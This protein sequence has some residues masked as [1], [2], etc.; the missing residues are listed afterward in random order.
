MAKQYTQKS[1]F[2]SKYTIEPTF[3]ADHQYLAELI[4]E[5]IAAKEGVKL[6]YNFWNTD[7]WRMVFVKQCKHA[8]DLLKEYDVFLIIAALKDF[9]CRKVYSLGARYILD[10]ILKDL[11]KLQMFNLAKEYINNKKDTVNEEGENETMRP[12]FVRK[13]P[14]GEL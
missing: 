8:S 5:R 11:V 7:R 6:S 14:L 1:R 9:R 3:V 4:C 10:P 2:Q 12:I 13:N